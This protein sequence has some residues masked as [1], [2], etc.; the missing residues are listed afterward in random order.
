MSPTSATGRPSAA[1]NIELLS[2]GRTWRSIRDS[3]H[4]VDDTRYFFFI[5][6]GFRKSAAELVLEA[7]R[8]CNQENLFTRLASDM[9]A[10]SAPVD[11][12]ASNWA[13]MVMASLAW[14]LEAWVAMSLPSGGRDADARNEERS[15]F[16]WM[17][18]TT[19]RR[20]RMAIPAQV[21]K[22]GRRIIFRLLPWNRW[23][24]VFFNLLDELRVPMRC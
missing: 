18:F 7:N 15:T 17:E 20:A 8:R 14:S 23:R 21:V 5:T 4:C 12:L 16:L 9:H 19:F 24:P 1:V 6:N 13:Y 22:T 10:L 3:A 11:T 2:S